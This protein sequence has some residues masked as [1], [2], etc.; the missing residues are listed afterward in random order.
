MLLVFVDGSIF[1]RLPG[2][3]ADMTFINEVVLGLHVLDASRPSLEP[4]W[5]SVAFKLGQL[6]A[7]YVI[8]IVSSS[9]AG[10]EGPTVGAVFVALPIHGGFLRSHGPRR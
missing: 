5:A 1:W 9:Q 7:G 6:M 8:V 2:L 10:V 3:I 4:P